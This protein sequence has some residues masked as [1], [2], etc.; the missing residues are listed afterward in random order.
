LQAYQITFSNFKYE[1]P[2]I[3]YVE[4][5]TNTKTKCATSFTFRLAQKEQPIITTKP[6]NQ[7]RG[8]SF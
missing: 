1:P 3:G 7:I 5:G 8:T 2:S 4:I 6:I